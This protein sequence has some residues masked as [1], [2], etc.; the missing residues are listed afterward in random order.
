MTWIAAVSVLAL[1]T[2]GTIL[3]KEYVH[4][5]KI[6]D[7]RK[8]GVAMPAGWNWITGHILT[9]QKRVQQFPPDVNVTLVMADLAREHSDTEIFL[10]DLWPFHLPLLIVY[11]PD[12]AVQMTTNLNLPKTSVHLTMMK[13]IT[14][15]ENLI[16]MNGQEWKNWRSLLNPGFST[17]AI[18]DSI[19]HIV[20][21]AKLFQDK[22]KEKAPEGIISLD[23]LATRMTMDV[24]M[25]VTLGADI[26]Y[27]RSD[28]ALARALGYIT[29]WHSFWD[30]QASVNSAI[31]SEKRSGGR[32]VATL[33]IEAYLAENKDNGLPQN[34]RLNK[35]FARDATY[36]IRLFLFAGNDTTSSTIVYVYHLLSQ[37]PEALKTMRQ[38]H[39]KVF[40][41]NI[42]SAAQLLIQRPALLSQCK[43]TIAVI[44]ET[45]RL[46]PPAGTMRA[47]G[48]GVSITDYCG[49]VYP[50]DYVCAT[51]IHQAVH[52]NPRVWPQPRKFLPDRI[53]V[54]QDHELYPYPPAFRPFEQGP[55]NCIGQ[56][57]VWNEIQIA[58][59][60]TV[61]TFDITP[62][63]E[64][65]DA[66]RKVGLL[67]RWKTRIMG[68]LVKTVHGDRAYQ[69]DKAGT[70]PADGYP[71]R[72]SLS[73][74]RSS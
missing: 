67:E 73:K 59:I 43:F 57:L 39:D 74:W 70:H 33:A 14:G 65:W 64:E 61:R 68:E 16:T 51:I 13:P 29:K 58:L 25:K 66:T 53:L 9:L 24:I 37:H 54:N 6:N 45:L 41:T 31:G 55:R 23:D 3:R 72:V 4:H 20:K 8:Q 27:Q 35:D 49:N 10:I 11:E 7:L 56:T 21:S 22:L 17:A 12:A 46:Y 32:S 1:T 63:Y 47:G 19:P 42:E 36:Q 26:D 34:N 18:N 50:M 38:E 69:T 2:L 28:N 48:P 30:P 40:G 71:C 60:L 5:S 15:G 44:K 62:A 52:L